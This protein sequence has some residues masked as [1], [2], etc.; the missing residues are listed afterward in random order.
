MKDTISQIGYHY[1][2]DDLH[3]TN[4][5]LSVWL[6]ILRSLGARWLTLKA[7]CDRAVPEN[8]LKSL[9]EN[10]ITP[11]IRLPIKIGT[12]LEVYNDLLAQYARW[13]SNMSSCTI[14]PIFN[15]AGEIM[16]G[17]GSA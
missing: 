13:A 12:P 4:A 3:Y 5:D 11:V 16:N 15:P 10:G 1:Y 17:P 9:M 6:P 8:F 14:A 7:S 2:P